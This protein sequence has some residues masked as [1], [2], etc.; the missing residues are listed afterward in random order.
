MDKALSD[1]LWIVFI[2]SVMAFGAIISNNKE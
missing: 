2:A 1:T